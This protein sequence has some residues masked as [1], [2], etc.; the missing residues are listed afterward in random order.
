MRGIIS[1]CL[2]TEEVILFWMYSHGIKSQIL[3]GMS[4]KISSRLMFIVVC[5]AVIA[6]LNA[7]QLSFKL[8]AH[9]LIEP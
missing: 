5:F 2:E 3:P 4:W 6:I 1:A 7:I 9:A 8:K